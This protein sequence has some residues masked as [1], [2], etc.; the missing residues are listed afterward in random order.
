LAEAK[1]P[2]NYDRLL[3]SVRRDW[4]AHDKTC[5]SLPHMWLGYRGGV[6]CISDWESCYDCGVLFSLDGL[7]WVNWKDTD[8]GEELRFCEC[9]LRKKKEPDANLATPVE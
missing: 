9:C 5:E 6:S 8:A 1:K 4:D 3:D 7:I 2:L